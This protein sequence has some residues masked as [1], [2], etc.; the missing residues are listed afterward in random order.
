M[1]MAIKILDGLVAEDEARKMIADTFTVKRYIKKIRHDLVN[2]DDL[3][4][5]QN[6]LDTLLQIIMDDGKFKRK[7]K[8][9]THT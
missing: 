7:R 3:D 9:R 5:L 6:L 8:E 2:L 1:T 4:S